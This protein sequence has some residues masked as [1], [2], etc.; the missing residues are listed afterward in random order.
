MPVFLDPQERFA[1]AIN[2]GLLSLDPTATNYVGLYMYMFT[3]N[4]DDH[5]KNIINRKYICNYGA[6]ERG[7][8]KG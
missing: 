1:A 6:H 5:F 7:R 2:R 3:D 4:G 8:E